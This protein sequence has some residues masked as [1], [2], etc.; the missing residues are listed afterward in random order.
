MWEVRRYNGPHSCM[1]T[2]IGQDH[3][4]LD[5]KVIA[6]HIFTMVKANPTISIRILQGGVERHFGYKASY[7]NVCLAKQRV[8]TRIYG[9]WEE[10]YNE[11][12]CGYSQCRCTWVQLVTQLWP[13][14]TNTVMFQCVFW[15]FPPCVEAF[16]HCKPLISIDGT[17]LYGKY[18]GTLLMAIA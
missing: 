14:S 6:Q 5:S 2:S 17:H 10:S 7:Q 16:K 9:D 1:Q 18:G 15:I 11:L 3:G 12:P 8:I 13:G 4:R